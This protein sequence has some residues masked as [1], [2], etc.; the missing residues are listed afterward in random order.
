ML[1]RYQVLLPDWLGDWV[2]HLVNMYDLS[3]SEII[4][5]EICYSILAGTANLYP[6]HKLGLTVQELSKLSKKNAEEEMN[7][8]EILKTI[9]KMYFE[10]RKAVEFR[11]DK[12]KE[13][14][15]EKK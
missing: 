2:E 6:D 5:A 14:K 12:E 9:S 7:R 3:F 10:T 4:R 13:N 1:K 11:L 8:D 15:K